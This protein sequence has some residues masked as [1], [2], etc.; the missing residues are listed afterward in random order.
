MRV[1]V[2]I[3]ACLGELISREIGGLHRVPNARESASS[4]GDWDCSYEKFMD[5]IDILLMSCTT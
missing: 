2:Y 4:S 3:A 5:P 1:S